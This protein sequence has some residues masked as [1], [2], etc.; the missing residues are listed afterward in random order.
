MLPGFF[1]EFADILDS[2]EGDPKLTM[3]RYW[4]TRYRREGG[5]DSR[6]TALVGLI[7]SGLLKRFES[8]SRAFVRTVTK[9]VAAHD[10]FARAVEAGVIPSSDS[11]AALRETDSDEAWE[12]LLSEGEPVEDDLDTQKLLEDV[13]SDRTLLDRLR[14]RAATVRA[15]DDPKLRLL[16]DELARIAATAEREGISEADVRNRRKVLVFS[17]FGD[18]VE[19]IAEHLGSVL[20]TDRR[21]ARYRGRLAIVRG[22]ESFEGV[23]RTDAVFGFAP[24]ST[25]APPGRADDKYDILVTTDVLA[26]GMNLQQC[27]RIINYDLPWNPMRLVQRHGR[28]DRI[29][30]PHENVFLTRVFPDRQL[31]AL[32][33]LE[34]RSGGSSRRRPPRSD[35]IRS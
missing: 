24:E 31:E 7:R 2:G 16:L 3:A 33:A 30:S 20:E 26:E 34:E 32:L 11:L 17:Y 13:R 9:M 35:S 1:D 12:A 28:I 18:T 10:D 19:W 22:T 8:S 6:E 14:D 4:P 29:G 25:E 23:T 5:P 27:G 15:A 21:L